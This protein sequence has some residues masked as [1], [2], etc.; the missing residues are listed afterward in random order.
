MAVVGAGHTVKL[1][2]SANDRGERRINSETV[3]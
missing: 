3:G 2:V 1:W